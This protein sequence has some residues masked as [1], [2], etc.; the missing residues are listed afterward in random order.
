MRATPRGAVDDS[1]DSALHAVS[2]A[3]VDRGGTDSLWRPHDRLRTPESRDG[4]DRDRRGAAGCPDLDVD[5]PPG[6]PHDRPQR[7]RL[8]PSRDAGWDLH[9]RYRRRAAHRSASGTPC[10]A[11]STVRSRRCRPASGPTAPPRG[12]GAARRLRR[13]GRPGD[14]GGPH[15]QSPPHADPDLRDV[16]VTD[17]LPGFAIIAIG[18]AVLL[19]ALGLATAPPRCRRCGLAGGRR[20]TLSRLRTVPGAC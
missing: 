12:A 20:L 4:G 3:V 10:S 5:S 15:P 2:G 8:C 7:S 6:D 16:R 13:R 1:R 19:R 14:M 9:D 17:L 11:R 18:A